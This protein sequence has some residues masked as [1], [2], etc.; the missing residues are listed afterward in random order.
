MAVDASCVNAYTG[1][2]ALV[3][4]SEPDGSWPD[5]GCSDEA[6]HKAVPACGERCAGH[7]CKHRVEREL[8]A[9]LQRHEGRYGVG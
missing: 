4:P 7:H 5:A 3:V 8:W 6:P 9:D 1:T 2:N